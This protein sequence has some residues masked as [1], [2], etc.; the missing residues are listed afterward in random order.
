MTESK[1][2]GQKLVENYVKSYFLLENYIIPKSSTESFSF[3]QRFLIKTK[4]IAF[5]KNYTQPIS[6]L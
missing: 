4:K 5:L 2:K 3:Y 1:N 6:N